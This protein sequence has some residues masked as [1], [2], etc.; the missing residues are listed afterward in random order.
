MRKVVLALSLVILLVACA[1]TPPPA[2]KSAGTC[3]LSE[4]HGDC[5]MAFLEVSGAIGKRYYECER[6]NCKSEC[7]LP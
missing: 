2:A 7:K 5:A 3:A 1:T 4:T 6:A